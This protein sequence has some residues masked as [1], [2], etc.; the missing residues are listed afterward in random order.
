[1]TDDTLIQ[2]QSFLTSHTTLSLATINSSGGP[3]TAPLFYAQAKDLK[4]IFTSEKKTMHAQNISQD[5]RVSGAIY[6]DGQEWGSIQGIQ[7]E[8]ICVEL[9]GVRLKRGKS[10]LYCQVSVHRQKHTP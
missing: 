3:Y 10:H 6:A 7:F 9:S 2:I 1:M 5:K 8:G 4:L